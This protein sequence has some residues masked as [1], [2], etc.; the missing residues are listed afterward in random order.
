MGK[1]E[2]Y[3]A[4]RYQM[5][6]SLTKFNGGLIMGKMSRTYKKYYYC[7][8]RTWL[9]KV[10]ASMPQELDFIKPL[11]EESKDAEKQAR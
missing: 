5:L 1:T 7:R 9:R 4:P 11:I 10:A 6:N 3:I 2:T 8:Y